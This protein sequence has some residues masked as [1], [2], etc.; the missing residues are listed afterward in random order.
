MNDEKIRVCWNCFQIYNYVRKTSRY[1][2]GSCRV[3]DNN[4]RAEEIRL[5][6]FKLELEQKNERM[7]KSFNVLMDYKDMLAENKGK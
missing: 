5:A 1:C 4:K 7:L 3:Q 6:V 2:S